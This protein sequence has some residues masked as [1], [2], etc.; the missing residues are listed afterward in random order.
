MGRHVA[1]WKEDRELRVFALG[2]VADPAGM[3]GIAVIEA[4]DAA[5]A[6]ELALNDPATRQVEY[7]F[8]YE[9][10]LMPYGVMRSS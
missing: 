4:A 6:Q 3:F 5:A 9:L 7:G 2:P 8:R 10:H 1:Y